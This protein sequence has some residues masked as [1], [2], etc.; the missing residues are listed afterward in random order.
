MTCE[1][2]SIAIDESLSLHCDLLGINVWF[3]RIVFEVAN[4]ELR[5]HPH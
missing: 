3:S 1:E 4:L 5:G 2:Q